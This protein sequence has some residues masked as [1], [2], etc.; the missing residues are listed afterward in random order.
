MKCKFLFPGYFRLYPQTEISALNYIRPNLMILKWWHVWLILICWQGTFDDYLELFLQ[1]GYVFLFSAVYPLAAVFAL[2]NNVIEVK[3]DAFK[4]TKVCRRPFGQAMA[5][6]GTWQVRIIINFYF[7]MIIIIIFFLGV[8]CCHL[9][10]CFWDM[11][12]ERKRRSEGNCKAGCTQ[13]DWMWN[14]IEKY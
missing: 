8:R 14:R 11:Q 3:S 4:L 1:F 9:F 2:L 7:C 12:N 10:F 13:P 6:I 5:D